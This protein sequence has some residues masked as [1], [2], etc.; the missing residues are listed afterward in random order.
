MH[1]SVHIHSAQHMGKTNFHYDQIDRCLS[2]F[3]L[4]CS[5]LLTLYLSLVKALYLESN[6]F[7]SLLNVKLV[8]QEMWMVVNLELMLN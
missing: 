2:A 1:Y 7:S 8:I 4:N 5:L 3:H 6:M